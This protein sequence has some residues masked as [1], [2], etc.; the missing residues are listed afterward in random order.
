MANALAALGRDMHLD[1]ASGAFAVR[2][3]HLPQP[4]TKPL[5][6]RQALTPPNMPPPNPSPP[7][8]SSSYSSSLRA[9]KPRTLAASSASPAAGAMVLG[10]ALS[11]RSTGSNAAKPTSATGVGSTSRSSMHH[12]KTPSHPPPLLAGHS[13]H[14]T[15][16][17]SMS[18]Q[19]TS[20]SLRTP[21]R[22]SSASVDRPPSVTPPSKSQRH[23]RSGPPS[24]NSGSSHSG[25]SQRSGRVS[26]PPRRSLRG[27]AKSP[28]SSTQEGTV[29]VAW[30]HVLSFLQSSPEASLALEALFDNS[31]KLSLVKLAYAMTQ[32]GANLNEAQLL[33]FQRDADVNEDGEVRAQHTAK[34]LLAYLIIGLIHAPL[35]YIKTT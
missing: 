20:D 13:H 22:V 15:N 33:A 5:R 31:W 3:P 25:G 16:R 1:E 30:R 32:L 12:R 7:Y 29:V 28:T 26:S 4:P 17:P 8:S 6:L 9:P 34:R 35:F 23:H 14:H 18:S 10:R 11:K 2:P 24:S 21:R 19:D 27:E